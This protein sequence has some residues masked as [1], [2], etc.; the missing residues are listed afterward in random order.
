MAR[1]K[2][3]EKHQG[4]FLTVNLYKQLLPGTFEWTVDYLINKA[5]VS[6]FEQK[7]NND[8][9]GAAAYHPKVLL[10][11]ILYCYSAG[12]ITSRYIE[13]ACQDNITVKALAEN[14]EPDHST[15]AAFISSNNEAIKNL[16]AQILLQCSRLKLITGEMFAIDG[17]K[18]SSNAS[19]E[20]SGKID[21]L[22]KKRDKLKKYIGRL[23]VIHQELDNNTKAKKINRRFEKTM[24]DAT[25]RRQRSN[26]NAEKK[27]KKLNE[28]LE[29]L[30]P[31]KGLSDAEV[32]SNI[33]DNESA[34]IKTKEGYI[35]GYN[36]ITIADS[37]NQVI[38][39]AEVT[40]SVAE[41]GKFPQMLETLKEN[42]K[43]IT[44][45]E[46]PLKKSIL[47][48]DTGYFTEE[49]LQKA[50]ELN[51]E[52]IMPDSQFRQRDPHFA[53]K[54]REK[55]EKKLFTKEDFKYNEETDVFTCPGGKELR[56]IGETVIGNNSGVKYQAKGKDCVECQ[57]IE[58]C[59]KNRKS[60]KPTDKK[61]KKRNPVRTL[62]IAINAYVETFCEK[63]RKKI[64]DPVYRE[65][66]SRRMQIIEPVFSDITYCKGMDR[67]TLRGEN[68]VGTQWKLYC[69]VHNIGKCMKPLA[70]KHRKSA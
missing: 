23:L 36:S 46:D 39:C 16:F 68:K 11:I 37:S 45:K 41:S 26:K 53:E 20:W 25:E 55:V 22:I 2:D 5:D 48:G 54:K 63:M 29:T 12:I 50:A 43:E 24:G 14:T 65:L 30:E 4:M 70:D 8:I 40:G 21:E 51:I 69:I 13:N 62:F 42:M 66:Y 34:L 31:R 59:I 47:L 64:D 35:Q 27:L 49:N 33:T 3:T 18:L 38:I 58:Q 6:L 15:I 56:N 61:Q 57:F 28:A 1:F 52:V 10:K 32:K 60:K 17:C 9:K 7:Y 44:G 67:F 19:K